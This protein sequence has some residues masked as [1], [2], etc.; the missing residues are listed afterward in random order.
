MSTPPR[1]ERYRVGDLRPSQLLYTFG[2]DSIIDLP[3]LSV[4]VMGLDDWS[5][6]YAEEVGEQ[7]LLTAVQEQL[8]PQVQTLRMLPTTHDENPDNPFDGSALVGVPVTTFPRWMVCPHCRLL[9]PRDS[10]LFQLKTDPMRP[11]RARYVH[12]NC[13]RPG[14]PP[15][16]LPARFLVACEKGHLDDFPW[17]YFAHQGPSDCNGALRLREFGVSGEAIDITIECDNCKA[18]RTMSEAFGDQG[19]LVMPMCRARHPHLRDF[20]EQSCDQQMR[21]ILLGA[22]NSWFGLTLTV[23]AVP[24]TTDPLT[25]LV[26]AQWHQLETITSRDLIPALRKFG[27]LNAFVNTSDD[28]LWT[29]IEHKRSGTSERDR[30]GTNLK[31]PEWR[32]LTNP[33]AA[34]R[35]D[36]FQVRAVAAP[37]AYA[38]QIE[39]VVLVERLRE[40]SACVGF[41]RITSPGDFAESGELPPD[42]RAPLSRKPPTWVSAVE[43]R[44]EGIFLGF[45]EQKIAAWCAQPTVAAYEQTLLRAH[46]QWRRAR[47]LTEPQAGFPG[48]RYAL[49]HTFAHALM[50]QLALACGY[51][52]ASLRERIYALKPADDDGP[53]AGVLIYTAAPDSEGTLGG[54]VSLGE[55]KQLDMHITAALQSMELCASDPLCA[56]HTPL[57]G[58]QTLHGAA[59]HACMFVPETSCERGNRYLDRSLIIPTVHRADLAF[60]TI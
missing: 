30:V 55:P 7:R 47:R 18:R 5:Q 2:I 3:N 12:V 60:F 54:L 45:D 29:A 8:G 46:I 33:T 15:T 4:M 42:H 11:D 19:R 20:D 34:P 40:V 49:L 52:M 31:T 14:A 16:V 56:E 50:R 39:R 10:G 23:L 1:A 59:C 13:S 17:H 43:V 24:Q 36:D 9:A 27:V 28:A 21:T 38:S 58:P 57:V 51:T 41:T 6:L 35:L 32:V 37:P 22:S 53:M 26:D 48:V 25:A 44:G